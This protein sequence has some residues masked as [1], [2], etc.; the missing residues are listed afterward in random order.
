MAREDS[1]S[2]N[3]FHLTQTHIQFL[4]HEFQSGLDIC[5]HRNEKKKN[6]KNFYYIK[7]LSYSFRREFKPI[8]LVLYVMRY[9]TW[10]VTRRV[11]PQNNNKKSVSGHDVRVPVGLE[12][13]PLSVHRW[14]EGGGHWPRGLRDH[15][16][17]A[18]KIMPT[19]RPTFKKQSWHL[20]R[21]DPQSRLDFIWTSEEEQTKTE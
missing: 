21:R 12:T 3:L 10:M 4:T 19:P 15:K 7:I 16:G 9:W 8:S 20:Y 1:G 18:R 14:Q 13:D 17:D 11:S 5:H 6:K 2:A